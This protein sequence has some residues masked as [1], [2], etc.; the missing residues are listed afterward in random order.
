MSSRVIIV[1]AGVAGLSAAIHLHRGGRE[2]TILEAS[3]APGGRVR[4]DVVNGF[5]LDRGFQVLLT[6]YPEAQRLLDY[7]AL[8]LKSFQPGAILWRQGTRYR[9]ADPW[10]APLEALEHLSP[11]LG[12]WQ[13]RWNLFRFRNEVKRASLHDLFQKPERSTQEAFRD[14]GFS[15]EMITGFLA[16]FYRGIFLEQELTTS[17]RMLDFTFKMFASG[18]TAVPA[19]GMAQ[20]PEQLAQSLPPDTVEYE[21]PVKEA[22]SGAVVLAD[23]TV[24]EADQVVVA[25][26]G[27]QAHQLVPGSPAPAWN[28]VVCYYYSAPQPPEAEALLVLNGDDTGPVNNV[29]VMSRVSDAL[30]PAGKELISVSVIDPEASPEATEQA[31][32]EQLEGWYGSMVREWELLRTYDLPQALPAQP[33]GLR[34]RFEKPVKVDAGLFVCG[35]HREHASL[36]G[37]MR[38]GRRAAEAILYDF[39]SAARG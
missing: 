21:T 29:A 20:I 38:A 34:N 1:G 16:P 39:D 4:T 18:N 32:R 33:V 24:R 31:V 6:A 11:M 7:S 5:R 36:Q 14:R 12:S 25:T 19:L 15:D 9:I 8:K 37:A 28:R 26:D 30:A 23:G 3:D 22:R 35:D 10:R 27:T 2:V 13:D 17:A